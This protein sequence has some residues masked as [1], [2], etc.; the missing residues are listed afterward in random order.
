MGIGR[1]F[2]T[3]PEARMAIYECIE[4]FYNLLCRQSALDYMLP[5]EYERRY[6]PLALKRKLQTIHESGG[7]PAWGAPSTLKETFSSQRM[8]LP[9][10]PH[11][12]EDR[13]ANT[14]TKQIPR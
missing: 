5:L 10:L 13:E 2:K 4:G 7:T 14:P 3:R 9:M 12:A 8:R 6:K 1:R 11:A